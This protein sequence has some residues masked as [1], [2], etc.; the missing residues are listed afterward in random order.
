MIAAIPAIDRLTGGSTLTAAGVAVAL[1]L[2]QII[3]GLIGGV[4]VVR[5]DRRKVMGLT[6]LIPAF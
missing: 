6:H 4:V 3:F 2:P 5:R 1:A